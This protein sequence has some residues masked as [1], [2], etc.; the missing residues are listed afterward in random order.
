[1]ANIYFCTGIG[2]V[3]F[4]P[5]IPPKCLFWIFCMPLYHQRAYSSHIIYIWMRRSSC[6][7]VHVP[8]GPAIRCCKHSG[9]SCSRGCI[10]PYI[11]TYIHAHTYIYTHTC[12]NTHVHSGI[13]SSSGSSSSG[14]SRSRMIRHTKE[15]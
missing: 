1:V 4:W 13:S 11:H 3:M 8:A 6:R 7:S 10:C 5:C 15:P 2:G 12:I 9:I 14:S